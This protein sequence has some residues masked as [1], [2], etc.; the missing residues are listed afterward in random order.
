MPPIPPM[1]PGA[2]APAEPFLGASTIAASVV[3]IR[4]ATEAASCRAVRTTLAGSMMP[5]V[6]RSMTKSHWTTAAMSVMKGKRKTSRS[7]QAAE[8]FRQELQLYQADVPLVLIPG[9]SH[10]AKAWRDAERP[11]FAWM[12]PQ[13]AHQASLASQAQLAR[14]RATKAHSA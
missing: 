7:V 10:D 14:E 1:P 3:I 2:P 8:S 13:L 4:P 6:I 9:A 12:T 5:A 11:M